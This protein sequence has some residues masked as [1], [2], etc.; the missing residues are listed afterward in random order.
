MSAGHPLCARVG[1]TVL[2]GKPPAQDTPHA[3]AGQPALGG[4]APAQDTP[5]ARAEQPAFGRKAPSPGTP[6]TRAGHPGSGDRP[7]LLVD[8]DGVISLFAFEAGPPPE[9]SFHAID[10]IPHFLSSK[11][12]EHL[13]AL[14]PMFEL[15]WASGWEEKANEYLPH[16]LGLPTLPHLSFERRVGRVNAHWKLDAIDAYAGER[17]LAWIDDAFNAACHAWAC[18]REAPTLLVQTTPASGLTGGE[19]ETL[20]RWAISLRNPTIS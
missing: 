2:E 17:A 20:E 7:L 8:I 4:K 14:A 18:A 3:H 9:G 1:G 19:A 6:H 10:G 16:L 11:A 5:H 13:L 12:A 15:A